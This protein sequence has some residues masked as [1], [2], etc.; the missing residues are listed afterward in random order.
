ME[1]AI[2]ERDPSLLPKC[3]GDYYE[4]RAR[5]KAARE[6]LYGKSP[7]SL[8]FWSAPGCRDDPTREVAV[9]G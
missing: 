5:T 7:P 1:R 4:R 6:E 9:P 8:D 3:T 2:R